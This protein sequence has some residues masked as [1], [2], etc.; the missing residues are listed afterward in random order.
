MSDSELRMKC[1]E[2]VV[3]D[4][5]I[6]DIES[7]TLMASTLASFVFHGDVYATKASEPVK[8]EAK[9]SAVN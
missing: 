2:I 3:R 1:L 8:A 5:G 7:A 9:A 6:F 4:L